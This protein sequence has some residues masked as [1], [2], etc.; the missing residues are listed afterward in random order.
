MAFGC[1]D[2]TEKLDGG[3]YPD[4]LLGVNGVMGEA[5]AFINRP[6]HLLQCDEPDGLCP[7]PEAELRALPSR[8]YRRGW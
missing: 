4:P 1:G 3:R 2:D 6:P 7:I 5:G 8:P